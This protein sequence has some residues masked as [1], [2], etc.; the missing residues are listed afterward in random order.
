M[1]MKKTI[2]S[3]PK[4]AGHTIVSILLLCMIMTLLPMA[5]A[6]SSGNVIDVGDST[7]TSGTGW[8]YSDGVFR[9]TGD[10]KIGRAHV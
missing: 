1:K 3:I 10:V 9:V 8:T 4:L 7:T 5:A 6:Q 2:S